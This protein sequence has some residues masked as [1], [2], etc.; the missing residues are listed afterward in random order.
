MAFFAAQITAKNY[1]FIGYTCS[2][3]LITAVAFSRLYLGAHWFSD[4]VGSLLLGLTILLL[5]IVS[6]RRMPTRHSALTLSPTAALCIVIIGLGVPWGVS[7]TR[8]FTETFNHTTPI[9]PKKT[10]SVHTWW[11]SPLDYT[12]LYRSDRLGQPFQPLNVQWQGSL[13]HIEKVLK[14]R[15]WES[16]VSHPLRLKTTLQHL[17]S[18]QA[19]YHLPLLVWLYRDKPPVL[20]LIKKIRGHNRIIELR[21]WESN[22]DFQHTGGPLWIGATD[23]RTAPKVLL[24]LKARAT[25]SLSNGGGLNILYQDT[26]DFQRKII[27]V[28]LSL[29]S[30]AIQKLQWNGHLLLIRSER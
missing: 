22:I 9:W 1:R 25:I 19:Q 4:I 16:L 24:S 5:C 29:K 23:I 14:N 8:T 28:A 17:A 21:L 11:Q 6:Y 12:P 13:Q 20:F 18:H 7:I 10:I 15:G 3:L 2:S 30:K 26:A 27:P